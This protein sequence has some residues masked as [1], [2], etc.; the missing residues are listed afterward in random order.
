MCTG[1]PHDFGNLK[2]SFHG[3]LENSGHEGNRSFLR[4][5]G[6]KKKKS[7]EDSEGLPISETAAINLLH[8]NEA[9][10]KAH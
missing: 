10:T 4:N 1:W 6:I 5:S 9:H 2:C 3:Y 8:E 7:S